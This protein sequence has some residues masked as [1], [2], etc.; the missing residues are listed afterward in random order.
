MSSKSSLSGSW[1]W[2]HFPHLLTQRLTDSKIVQLDWCCEWLWSSLL[3]LDTLICFHRLQGQHTYS[4]PGLSI[5]FESSPIRTQ[6][7]LH[8][9]SEYVNKWINLLNIPILSSC[10]DACQPW[11]WVLTKTP[12]MSTPQSKNAVCVFQ[13]TCKLLSF[14]LED[15]WRN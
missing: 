3:L 6:V 1:D 8:I 9:W 11:W 13:I 12:F 10:H 14:T 7:C 2:I 15:Y 5:L 4:R